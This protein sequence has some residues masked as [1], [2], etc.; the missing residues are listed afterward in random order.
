MTPEDLQI[1]KTILS[2]LIDPSREAINYLFLAPVDTS[3]YTDYLTYVS[4][5]MD[6]QT[7]SQNIDNEFYQNKEEFYTDVQL[8][9]ENAIAFN[10]G[11]PTSGFVIDLAKKMKGV[12]ERERKKAERRSITAASSSSNTETTSSVGDKKKI[13][14]T[15]KRNSVS[16]GASNPTD[17]AEDAQASNKAKV[18]LGGKKITL[19][20]NKGKQLTEGVASNSAQNTQ[21]S[22]TYTAPSNGSTTLEDFTKMAPMNHKRQ[23]QCYKVLSSLKRRQA[24]NV[25]HFLKPVSDAKLVK[26]YKARIEF[27]ID[28]GTITSK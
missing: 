27:P 25:R 4:K 24:V 20:L 8:I 21:K 28:L 1:S 22:S 6:L 2:A 17:D 13:K 18:S 14:L 9:W 26:D 23:A 3:I 7:L 15:L 12:F 19:K 11:K 10:K 16:G 5:P